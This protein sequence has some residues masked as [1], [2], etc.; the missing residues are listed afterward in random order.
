MAQGR[1]HMKPRVEVVEHMGQVE[2]SLK[3]R[4]LK[5]L[6][7]FSQSGRVDFASEA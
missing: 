1:N 7:G 2:L 6:A 3:R 4:Q 5:S